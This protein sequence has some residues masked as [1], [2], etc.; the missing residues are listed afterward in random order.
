MKQLALQ[1]EAYRSIVQRFGE[2]LATVGYND[3][4]VY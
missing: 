1:S 4:A 2:W 3:Q